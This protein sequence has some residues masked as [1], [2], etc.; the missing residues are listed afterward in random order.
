MSLIKSKI[1][2]YTEKFIAENFPRDRKNDADKQFELFVNSMHCW[3]VSSQSY[4]SNNNIGKEV[5]LGESQGADAFFVLI[6]NRIYS[7]N[8]NIS[9][10]LKTLENKPTTE[11]GFQFIQTKNTEKAKLGDFLKFIEIPLKVIKQLPMPNDKNLK[12]VYTFIQDI[13]QNPSLKEIKHSFEL[14]FYTTKG[15]NDVK[16]QKSNWATDL[17]SYR[18][19]LSYWAKV[20][21]DIR[22]SEYLNNLFELY[23]SNDYV[24][25]ATKNNLK[26]VVDE[27]GKSECLI[28]HISAQELLNCIAPNTNGKRVLKSDVFKHNIRLYLGD[29]TSVN[30]GIEK[31]LKDE[32]QL[33]HLYNNGITITT[34]E[35]TDQN[36]YNFSISPVNIVNGCQTANSIF[37]VCS[38]DASFE[39]KIKIPVKIIKIPDEENTKITIRSNSQNGVSETDLLAITN[40]QIDLET[41]FLAQKIWDFQFYYK[42]QNSSNLDNG[43]YDFTIKIDDILRAFFSS[44]LLI[45]HKVTAKFNETSNQFLRSVFEER[46]I[47]LYFVSTVIYKLIEDHLVEKHKD[48]QRLKYHL[49]Y[50]I[51]RHTNSGA[52]YSLLEKYFKNKN[53]YYDSEQDYAEKK[54]E[55]YEN[56]GRIANQITGNLI[57]LLRDKK[58]FYR[59]VEELFNRLE[60]NNGE[61]FADL[62]IKQ[63]ERIIYKAVSNIDFGK[64]LDNAPANPTS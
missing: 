57:N 34:K 36:T 9:D 15:E 51:Y 47:S 59:L 14:Y 44:I 55:E 17:D 8:D 29:E 33:F 64:V 12:K 3:N 25:S 11:I 6:N 48:N 19:D 1:E 4:Q 30:E 41:K 35:I 62:S 38:K 27:D 46:F 63:N 49:S 23:N 42:R 58:S 50:L 43:E 54:A 32:Y 26:R 31:T 18:N 52:E 61:F 16:K 7:L 10:V 45:P 37:N 13:L 24:L 53:K 21:I 40:I 22:G 39:S 2:K 20:E 60:I 28:G 56:V 5:S